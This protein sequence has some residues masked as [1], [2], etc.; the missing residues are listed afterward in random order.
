MMTLNRVVSRPQLTMMCEAKDEVD[1]TRHAW[2][3]A[4][5]SPAILTQSTEEHLVSSGEG[6]DGQG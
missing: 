1:D 6:Q 3:D 5:T 4:G 2:S